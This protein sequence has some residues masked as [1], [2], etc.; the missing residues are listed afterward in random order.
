MQSPVLRIIVYVFAVIG[1]LVVV[2]AIGMFVMHGA[3]VSS[4]LGDRMM[5]GCGATSVT[6][7]RLHKGAGVQSK[8]Q[9]ILRQATRIERSAHRIASLC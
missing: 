4:G 2:G 6:S 3:M 1:L 7:L 9:G 8:D 5:C